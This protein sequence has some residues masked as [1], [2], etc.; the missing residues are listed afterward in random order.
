MGNFSI[1]NFAKTSLS[2]SFLEFSSGEGQ[3]AMYRTVSLDF[4]S[5]PL[6]EQEV[7]ELVK[8][9]LDFKPEEVSSQMFC[10]FATI[11]RMG[12]GRSGL[13]LTEE[14]FEAFRKA[15]IISSN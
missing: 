14:S 2:I 3:S 15:S 1:I 10:G 7:I 12:T 4:W 13:F 5:E 6:T 9:F 11:Y 8:A